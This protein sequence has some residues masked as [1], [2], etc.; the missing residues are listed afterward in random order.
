MN[1]TTIFS[2]TTIIV[3]GLVIIG[4]SLVLFFVPK[5]MFQPAETGNAENSEIKVIRPSSGQ[6]ISS[7]LAVEG[8]ARGSWFFEAQFPITITDEQGNILGSAA[9][10]AQSDWMTEDFVPFN[11]EIAFFAQTIRNGFLVLTNDNPSG[12]PENQK[13][14][15]I[16]VVFAPG[17][18]SVK[19]FFNSGALDPEMTCVK[20][21]PIIREFSGDGDAKIFAL[22]ELIK[23]PSD[24]EK[25]KGYFTNMNEGVKVQ[26]LRVENNTAFVD[27]DDQLEFQAGGSC[28]VGAIRVQITETLKQ[29]AGIENVV[30]SIN[31]RTED[32]LQ[33]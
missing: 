15:K 21:F 16:P 18:V 4:L 5:T 25:S 12:L 33:P 23:G 24:A 7:P 27:F 26:S 13:Q 1:K 6:E 3:L 20:V 2:L 22:E 14:I 10:I 9:A 11:A 28:K 17:P 19:V 29:F 32:I 8:E 31:G 30:I